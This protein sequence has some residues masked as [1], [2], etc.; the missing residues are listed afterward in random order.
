MGLRI[1][2]IK[3]EGRKV[4][5]VPSSRLESLIFVSLMPYHQR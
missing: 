1:K 2:E 5:L 3:E 4:R